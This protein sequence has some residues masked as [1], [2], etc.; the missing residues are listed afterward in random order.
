MTSTTHPNSLDLEAFA[1]G[2]PSAVVGAHV[3]E[4]AACN[5]FV[6]RAKGALSAGPSKKKALDVVALA[7]TTRASAKPTPKRSPWFV[8]STLVA[9][10][11]AAAALLFL[12]RTPSTRTIVPSST[13]PTTTGPSAVIAPTETASD[14]ET[15]FKGGVQIAVIRERD[16]KQARF[17]SSVTVK[18]GDR[19]RVEVALDRE[20]TILAAVMGEDA[21]WLELM[22]SGPRRP[23]THFS[24]RSAR[25]D[26]SPLRG[27]VIVGSPEAV[28]RARDTRR[29]EGVATV[30]IEWEAPQK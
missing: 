18:P 14:P 27:T 22:S 15:T 10:L 19:L 3:S 20:Q 28:S 1:V 2:E 5:A 17:T 29:F 12:L 8:A 25:V 9:P 16:G 21:S 4:C 23:G 7:A 30:R 11:A 13:A 24:D 6:E 26:A